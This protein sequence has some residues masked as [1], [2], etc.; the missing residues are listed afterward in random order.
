MSHGLYLY[1][2][3]L[4]ILTVVLLCTQSTL[5]LKKNTL[6][7]CLSCRLN[8]MN[9]LHGAL[10]LLDI[11]TDKLQAMII[12][13]SVFDRH[14]LKKRAA[15]HLKN[16]WDYL[17]PMITIEFS[18]RGCKFR[19]VVS[20]TMRVISSQ[21]KAFL[22]K[23]SDIN[24]FYLFYNIDVLPTF[25]RKSFPNYQCIVLLNHAWINKSIQ[26]ARQD[27]RS[28]FC[29]NTWSLTQFLTKSS[30]IT[31]H[32]LG[33]RSIFCSKEMTLGG[34]RLTSGWARKTKSWWE[35]CNLE[36]HVPS[37]REIYMRDWIVNEQSSLLH[38]TAIKIPKVQGLESFQVDE[39]IHMLGGWYISTPQ[40]R[41]FWLGT[42][43]DYRGVLYTPLHLAVHPLS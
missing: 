15:C 30:Y 23:S 37:S 42:F 12:Q 32:F 36:P 21:Y 43:P 16:K 24:N 29:S 33:D 14:F 13:T 11:T 1:V 39:H 22:V 7:H 31:W 6:V 41:N 8:S 38:E 9:F 34:S 19:K 28:I 5:L 26:R 17:L 25:G 35:A 20:I 27:P 4:N 40:G 2:T 10:F 3:K 18:S